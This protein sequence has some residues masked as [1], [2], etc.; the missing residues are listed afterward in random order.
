M[1]PEL[2]YGK[3]R[4]DREAARWFGAA[5]LEAARGARGLRRGGIPCGLV[6]SE[7]QPG[8]RNS[9]KGPA[10]GNPLSPGLADGLAGWG[11]GAA[12]D[13][14]PGPALLLRKRNAVQALLWSVGRLAVPHFLLQ[15]IGRLV[16]GHG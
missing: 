9:A 15:E 5:R 13:D 7:W 10:E 4:G 12:P 14:D 1:S 2:L 8:G 16:K 3:C 6:P 11:R